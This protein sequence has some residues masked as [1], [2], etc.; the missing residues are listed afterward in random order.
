[1]PHPE[2]YLRQVLAELYEDLGNTALISRSEPVR[3]GDLA[4]AV[5]TAASAMHRRGIGS[6][7]LVAVLT[8]PNTVAT[9]RW[10][11][12]LPSIT[13]VH[14]RGVNVVNLDEELPLAAQRPKRRT[15][16]RSLCG[17]PRP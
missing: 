14:I 15:V 11:V 4:T 16:R 5:E 10:P 13:V 3:V 9:L 1:M 8:D 17:S 7:S 12:N 2:H 6:G